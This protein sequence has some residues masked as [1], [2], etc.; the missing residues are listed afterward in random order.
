MGHASLLFRPLPPNL[1][2]DILQLLG[3]HT[4]RR[5]TQQ[6]L[7]LL[8]L[9]KRDYIPD[10]IRARQQHDQPVQPPGNPAVRRRPVLQRL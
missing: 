2:I 9:R 1:Q 3:I 4:R 7:P 6:A 8:R 10:I 5:L